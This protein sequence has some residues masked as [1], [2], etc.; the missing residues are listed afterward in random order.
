MPA[1]DESPV[2]V[3]QIRSG[4]ADEK[5]VLART[6]LTIVT[7][8][9]GVLVAQFLVHLGVALERPAVALESDRR[10]TRVRAMHIDAPTRSAIIVVGK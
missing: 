9:H 10:H 4:D 3:G 2:A 8:I 5:R 1:R 6:R 7:S